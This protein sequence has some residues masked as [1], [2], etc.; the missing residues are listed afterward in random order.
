MS[1]STASGTSVRIASQ[2]SNNPS[3]LQVP[4]SFFREEVGKRNVVDAFFD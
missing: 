1:Q 4:Y 3:R 2:A